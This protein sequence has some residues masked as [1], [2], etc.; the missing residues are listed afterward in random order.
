[1]RYQVGE[2]MGM[3]AVSAVYR[4]LDTVLHR[5]VV[6]KAVPPEHVP[7]YR[8]ALQ[9]SSGLTHPAIVA[10]YDA[11]ELDQ[12]LFLVQ[13]SVTARSLDQYLAGGVPSGR[14]LDLAAQLAR[15]LAYAHSHTVTHGDLTPA[16][17]LVDRRAIVHVNNFAL[18]ADL[19][20]F[21]SVASTLPG[22]NGEAT[23]SSPAALPSGAAGDVWAVG[24]LLWQL[25]SAPTPQDASLAVDP[26]LAP[27]ELLRRE[28]RLDVREDVR[29]L[30][31]RCILPQHPHPIADAES[32]TLALEMETRALAGLHPPRAEVT[33]PAL[34][35]A[36]AAIANLPSWSTEDT[37]GKLRGWAQH[38]DAAAENA[39]PA[40]RSKTPTGPVSRQPVGRA[41]L[42]TE[43]RLGQ[44]RIRLP[45]L[46]NTADPAA[47]HQPV[48]EN[49]SSNAA[50]PRKLPPHAARMSD[51]V[52]V[53][54][55]RGLH[56]RAYA[57]LDRDK[58]SGGGL[59]MR[60]VV[61]LGLTLFLLAFV[62]GFVLAALLGGH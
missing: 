3:G 32:L 4:G 18:P 14:A 23:M 30:V 51:R 17:I 11:A 57:E 27:A 24:L 55:P 13:E 56:P 52:A 21:T 50:P 8:Q 59:T 58:T 39:R 46:P 34:R 16:A 47:Y 48:P 54:K 1:M 19:H 42:A 26:A 25:L 5:P 40:A 35:A 7:A 33:P 53:Q 22:R 28:F 31:R 45:S 36:R 38:A 2:S 29:E 15:A 44:P 49:W 10:T 9:V 6:V 37:Q 62:V 12:W 61:L 43:E 41:P 60:V 20:Y